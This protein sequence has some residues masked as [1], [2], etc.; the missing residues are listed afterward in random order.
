MG[1]AHINKP[2]PDV[3]LASSQA[4]GEKQASWIQA[5]QSIFKS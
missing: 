5:H 1:P 3:P 2:P 4:E